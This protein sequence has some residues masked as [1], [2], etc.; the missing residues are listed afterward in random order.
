[1]TLVLLEIKQPES[2]S[3]REEVQVAQSQGHAVSPPTGFPE[4][5]RSGTACLLQ[6]P[7]VKKYKNRKYVKNVRWFV[8]VVSELGQQS[9]CRV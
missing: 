6:S 9:W 5:G 1:M 7:R 3:L 4:S 2:E 8:L